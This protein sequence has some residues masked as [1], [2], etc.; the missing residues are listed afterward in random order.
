MHNQKQYI[1]RLTIQREEAHHYFQIPIPL[2]CMKITGI[3]VSAQPFDETQQGLINY[4]M[5]G[6]ISLRLPHQMEEFYA[7]NVG[8]YHQYQPLSIPNEWEYDP[9]QTIQ[10]GGVSS[11]KQDIKA[12]TVLL[13]IY[14]D[15]A[16][17]NQDYFFT[18][19]VNIYL[20]YKTH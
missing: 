12:S 1:H 18:Y 20:N 16:I 11:R 13:G 15:Y 9:Y 5:Q 14:K 4:R 2:D 8:E 7:N 10:L 17:E 6:N 3:K 19:Q